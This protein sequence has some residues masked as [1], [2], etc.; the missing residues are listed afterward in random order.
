MMINITQCQWG[1]PEEYGAYKTHESTKNCYQNKNETNQSNLCAY[2]INCSEKDY[3][4]PTANVL[5]IT[6]FPWTTDMRHTVLSHQ[7]GIHFT[8]Y[9]N[10]LL[11]SSSVVS[12]VHSWWYGSRSLVHWCPALAWKARGSPLLQHQGHAQGQQSTSTK[13][14]SSVSACG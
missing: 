1:N 12:Q 4:M 9:H 14:S 13:H 5:D 10:N 7:P 8:S 2:H 3:S 6:H 11:S